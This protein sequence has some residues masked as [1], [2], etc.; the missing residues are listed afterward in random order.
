MKSA[1][2]M[3]TD[4]GTDNLS[5]STMF[6]VAKIVDPELAIYNGTHSVPPFDVLTASEYLMY[7]IPFWPVGTVF[8]SVV[9]PGVG[10]PRKASIAKLANGSYVVTPDN[11]TLTY[12]KERIGI[13]EI[14]EIDET[15]NRFPTTRDVHIFHGRDLFAYC[16]AKL[17][18]G[19]IDFEGVGPAYP[20]EDV[21]MVDYIHATKTEKGAYGMVIEA[22]DHFGLLGTNIPFGWLAEMDMNY[23]D[24]VHVVIEESGKVVYDQVMALEKSFG[25]VPVNDPV[26]LSSE[27][28]M[29][30]IAL[31]RG[32]IVKEYNLH[33]GP[34]CRF[35]IEKA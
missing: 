23:G 5:V 6:G 31:N 16:G 3:Q 10:T 2:V 14:R 28:S 11:G 32:N 22:T 13:V 15:V 21:V 26:C 8:V 12:I 20:V 24:K 1:L 27:T 9:D 35:T 4:F 33:Y 30:M 17:A 34:E 18:S 29:V 7:Q 25:Y 19:V